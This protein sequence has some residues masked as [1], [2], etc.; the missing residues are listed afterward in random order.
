MDVTDTLRDAAYIAVGASILGFQKAQVRRRELIEELQTRRAWVESQ[1]AEGRTSFD[2]LAARFE[3]VAEPVVSEF[4]ARVEAL[5]EQLR[6]ALG[7]TPAA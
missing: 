5:I 6:N 2:G 3:E 4:Q 1:M 7:M